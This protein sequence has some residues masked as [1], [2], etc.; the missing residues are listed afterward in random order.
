MHIIPLYA[1]LLALLYLGLSVR[2]IRW[3][4]RELVALGDGGRPALQ[5][6]LRVHGNF[7]EYVPFALLMF[8]MVEASGASVMWVHGLCAALLLGRLIHAYGVSQTRETLALR[9]VGMVLTFTP[10]LVA[11]GWVLVRAAA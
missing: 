9:V 2:V 11:A 8:W 5:R 3:R 1:A 7:A 10:L 4:R 6:A